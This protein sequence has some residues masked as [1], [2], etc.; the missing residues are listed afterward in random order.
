MVSP[1]IAECFENLMSWYH[2][3]CP[4]DLFN[5][6]IM[7]NDDEHDYKDAAAVFLYSNV[8]LDIYT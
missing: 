6:Q 2:L 8:G 1:I 3:N 7:V 4:F 5:F